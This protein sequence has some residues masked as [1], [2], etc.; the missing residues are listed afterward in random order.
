M[1]FFGKVI[2]GLE[3]LSIFELLGTSSGKPKED[4]IIID[5]GE[6]KS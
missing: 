4:A 2:S 1:L 6:I 3:Y 5:S